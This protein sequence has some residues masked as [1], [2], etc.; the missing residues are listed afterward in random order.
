MDDHE[1]ACAACAC[2][3]A[4]VR[5]GAVRC[6]ACAWPGREGAGVLQRPATA[7][8]QGRRPHRRP[9]RAADHQRAH[10][11]VHRVRSSAWL[12][13][14]LTLGSPRMICRRPRRRM[15]ARARV[16]APRY[17]R[18][19]SLTR[20]YAHADARAHA[21]ARAR[22]NTHTPT[23]ACTQTRMHTHARTARAKARA[24]VLSPCTAQV[25]LG[26]G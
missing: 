8:D 25:W 13:A 20:V 17:A 11:C 15:A 5:C 22:P 10:R 19:H 9:Q 16:H 21:P 4:C 24:V 3:R 1:A 2:V 12:G 18:I 6:G 23:R 26:R 14:A 7:S